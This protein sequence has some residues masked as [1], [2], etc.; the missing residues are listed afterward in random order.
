MTEHD[1]KRSRHPS[2]SPSYKSE[3]HNRKRRS[4]SPSN[5]HHRRRSK[6]PER[7]Q[8]PPLLVRKPVTFSSYADTPELSP[9]VKILCQIVSTS[10]A[11]SVERVLDDTGIR[12]SQGD[13]EDVLKLS[14]GSPGP[15]VK[16]FRWSGHQLVDKHS[17]YAWNLVVDMLGKNGLFDAMWDA[18]KSMKAEAL[19]SLATFASVFSSYVTA[20][21]VK[22]AIMTFEVMNQYGVSRNIGALNSLLSAICRDGKTADAVD[23]LRIAKDKISPDAD[24]Y[25]ILLEGLENERD[26]FAAKK[27]FNEMVTEIGWDP[28][29]VPAY[30]SYLNTLLKGPD[31]RREAIRAFESLCDKR[32]FPGTSFL[33]AA[34]DECLKCDDSKRAIILW[35]EMVGRNVCTPDTN[36]YNS[37]ISLHCQ[38]NNSEMARRLMD[39]MV[40]KGA[41]PDSQ[42]YNIL[43]RFF[44][45]AKK[46]QDATM[47]FTEMVKNEFI[48]SQSNC[49]A[50]LKTSIDLGDPYVA[51]KIWK[52]MLENYDSDLEETGNMLIVGL[53]DLNKIPEAVKYAEALIERG[54]KLNSSTLSKLKQSL[55]KQRKAVVYDELL[56]KWKTR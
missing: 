25:A 54:I 3:S 10:D 35:E 4:R 30:N 22:E 43:L 14:Y 38:N 34:L 52:C 1:R 46:L 15:A 17:P 39:E 44:I 16:F 26:A 40:F 50:A 13:V 42:T 7:N 41:F 51:I 45:N 53:R 2:R 56:K 33:K 29:N 19:V 37:M 12:V 20:D 5:S 8:P 49:L 27:F 9:K 6:F 36:M 32:C 48:P 28:R 24:T 21:R 31:G 23:F 11:G 18:I 55:V 47:I